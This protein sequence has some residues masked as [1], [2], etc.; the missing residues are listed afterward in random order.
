MSKPYR[1]IKCSIPGGEWEFDTLEET[2]SALRNHICGMCLRDEEFE[3]EADFAP[4]DVYVDGKII[5]CRDPIRLL[6]TACGLEYEIEGDLGYWE[7]AA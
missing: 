4:V 2:V 6:G 1:L 5:E 3:G 7:R